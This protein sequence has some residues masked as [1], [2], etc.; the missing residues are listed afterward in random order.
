MIIGSSFGQIKTNS[1]YI[2]PW[3]VDVSVFNAVALI[4][5]SIYEAFTSTPYILHRPVH[6]LRKLRSSIQVLH[7]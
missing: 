5:V 2:I 1:Y 4:N 6:V 7:Y 3:K